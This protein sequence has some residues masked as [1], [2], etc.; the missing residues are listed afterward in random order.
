M[1]A[2]IVVIVLAVFVLT[3]AAVG[4]VVLGSRVTALPYDPGYDTRRPMP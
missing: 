3:A 1:F 2:L 4:L